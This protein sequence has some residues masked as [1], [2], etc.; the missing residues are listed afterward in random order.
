MHCPGGNASDPIGRVLASSPGISS[1]TYLKL[2]HT[3]P[4]PNP[5][6]HSALTYWLPYSYHTSHHPS[7]THCLPWISQATQK[8]ILQFSQDGRKAVWNIPYVSVAFFPS[9][10]QNF[11]AYRSSI[12]FSRPDCFF[13]IQQ[14]FSRVYSNCYYS[15]SFEPVIIKNLS[16]TS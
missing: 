11:I 5:F 14:L 7:Q 8:L 3:N 2:Q 1:W 12:L 6:G 4:I 16:V 10:K 13:E 15:C 9:L